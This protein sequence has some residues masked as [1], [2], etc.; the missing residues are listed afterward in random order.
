MTGSTV[1]LVR[2]E[3]EQKET[4]A[5]PVMLSDPGDEASGYS[6]CSHLWALAGRFQVRADPESPR[7]LQGR[8]VPDRIKESRGQGALGERRGHGKL[9]F[10]IRKR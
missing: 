5:C 1:P 7:W 2:E 4:D 9:L 6:R 10:Y 8:R 3:G